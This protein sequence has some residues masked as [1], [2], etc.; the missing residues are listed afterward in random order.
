MTHS[1]ARLSFQPNTVLFHIERLQKYAVASVLPMVLIY[2]FELQCYNCTL[3]H[4]T[5]TLTHPLSGVSDIQPWNQPLNKECFR[6]GKEIHRSLSPDIRVSWCNTPQGFVLDMQT[7]RNLILYSAMDLTWVTP[8]APILPNNF[9][10]RH[11]F[12]CVKF[13]AYLKW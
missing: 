8:P 13:I 5:Y 6:P 11:D 1:K 12:C 7:E 2:H 9:L 10:L 3:N 4:T